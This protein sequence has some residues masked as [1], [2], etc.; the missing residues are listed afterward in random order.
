MVIDDYREENH[1]EA[2]LRQDVLNVV[3]PVGERCIDK[4][5]RWNWFKLCV[6]DEI[7]WH[8]SLLI[9]HILLVELVEPGRRYV[10]SSADAGNLSSKIVAFIAREGR[11]ADNLE[12]NVVHLWMNLNIKLFWES[13]ES[14][15]WVV[16]GHGLWICQ[17]EEWHM[18]EWI[19]Q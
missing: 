8:S 10:R 2:D 6:E 11:V 9:I 14:A 19:K 12:E 18:E 7:V 5:L 13:D 1:W 3:N 15:E 4:F 17:L 16:S